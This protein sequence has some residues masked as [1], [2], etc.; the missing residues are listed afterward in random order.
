[1]PSTR[2]ERA[3]VRLGPV[4]AFL[5]LGAATQ[6]RADDWLA[7][8]PD[9]GSPER[10]SLPSFALVY[11]RRGLPAV[12]TAGDTLIARVRLP[13]ALTP[14]PGIQQPR[15]LAGWRAELAGHAL[16][17]PAEPAGRL[18]RY[19]Y[20]LEVVDVRPDG[21]SSLVYRA[22]MPIPAWVAPG[23]YDLMLSAPG[24][25]GTARGL[26]RVLALGQTVR[27]ARMADED[28]RS[29]LAVAALPVDVWV[30]SAR[31]QPAHADGALA[32]EASVPAPVLELE[33]LVAALRM[34]GGVWTSGSCAGPFAQRRFEDE[35]AGVLE[36]ERSARVWS[37]GEPVQR[38]EYRVLGAAA[39][40][41]PAQNEIDVAQDGSTLMIEASFPSPG[42]ELLVLPAHGARSV[43]GLGATVALFPGG[44]LAD[45]AVAPA[46]VALLRIAPGRSVRFGPGPGRAWSARIEL[47]KRALA[48]Y[49]AAPLRVRGAPSDARIAW[50]FDERRTAFGPAAVE[51][52]FT[53]LGEHRIDAV[54]LASDGTSER[55]TGTLRVRTARASGCRCA[56]V[57]GAEAEAPAVL[58]VLLWPRR[59]SSPL[60]AKKAR[61]PAR[62]E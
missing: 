52:S 24:G 1:M 43:P 38:G 49:E 55:L 31:G 30:R 16:A 61:R 13:V 29:D 35:V 2:I 56:T 40:P 32:A 48:T 36:R 19:G 51:R 14:P 10:S 26:L 62:A 25:Q 5:L 3:A 41:L 54:A 8:L 58:A 53:A 37:M 9:C 4:L 28:L 50:R 39:R 46:P 57:D 44:D 23:S 59:R 45:A 42:A 33:G 47:P 11:P 12:V 17:L 60:R 22:S 27:L 15:A 20:P 34:G 18:A 21:A 7:V 6:A